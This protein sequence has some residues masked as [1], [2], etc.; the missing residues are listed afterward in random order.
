MDGS[1]ES[2]VAGS[3]VGPWGTLDHAIE[4]V[5]RLRPG[6]WQFNRFRLTFEPF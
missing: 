1:S 2:N 3:D 4:E 5:R 6:W